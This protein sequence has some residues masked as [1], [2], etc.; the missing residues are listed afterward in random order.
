MRF[1][2]NLLSKKSSKEKNNNVVKIGVVFYH[3]NICDIYP[4]DWIK[5]CFE[6]IINQSYSDFSIYEL[7]YGDDD[8]RLSRYFDFNKDYHYYQ[9]KFNNHADAMNCVL[10]KAIE[11]GCDYVFNTNMDDN[12]HTNRFKTQISIALKGY[13]IV[14][15][16]FVYID[17]NGK[18]GKYFDF[19]NVNIKDNLK[20]DNNVIA[21]PSVCYSKKFILENKY[22]SDKIPR[23]DLELWKSTI[24]KYKFFICPE[25]LLNYRIHQNQ[26]SRPNSTISRKVKKVALLVIATNK[27]VE[28]INQLLES[29]DKY[30]LNGHNVEYFIF[31]NKDIDSELDLNLKR[32]YHVLS[33]QHKEWPW[34]T[35]GRYHIFSKHKSH[36]SDFDYLYYCDVDMK[37]EDYIGEEI[38]GKKV[39]T[40]HPGYYEDNTVGTPERNPE[41]TAYIPEEAK[42]LYYAGGFNG[43]ETKDFLKMSDK[44]SKNIDIDA[45]KNI[46]AIWHDESHLNH[47]FFK[48]K[49]TLILDP[50]YCYPENKKI[51]FK[52]KLIA[53]DKNHNLLREQDIEIKVKEEENKIEGIKE[54]Y[55]P[56]VISRPNICRC[57]AIIDRVRYNF[58]Q[59][60]GTL[61]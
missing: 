28:F 9:R 35:L 12:Y 17:E 44:L 47:Y 24:N 45:K 23:E 8:F 25:Y 20:A 5:E 26:V 27:Y 19:S 60:C 52:K 32:K 39:V 30:F 42:N 14:S 43:G 3:S 37:F 10:D 40:L 41:S 29:A 50:G 18:K 2:L 4:M 55:I 31:T 49:P 54:V 21:H 38:F 61:Y 33:V 34:M 51:P 6:S 57:G 36:Y 59:K 56:P 11:D 16:N 1:L 22:N 48:N 13:D 58:C 53:I 46:I 15:S 7:N